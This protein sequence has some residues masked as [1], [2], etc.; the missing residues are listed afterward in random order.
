[1]LCSGS[2]DLS[3]EDSDFEKFS[4]NWNQFIEEEITV[5][6]D[7]YDFWIKSGVPTHLVRYEDI[8]KQPENTMKDLMKFIFIQEDIEETVL[9]QCIKLVTNEKKAPEVYKPR[10]GKINTNLAKFS[11]KQLDVIARIAGDLLKSLGYYS[12][13]KQDDSQYYQEDQAYQ[14]IN[15]V[16]SNAF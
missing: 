12:L 2:H 8:L 10:V 15:Q 1:M 13:L 3:I 16:N 5:W 7:F 11:Q 4:F 6:R 9:S 14:W